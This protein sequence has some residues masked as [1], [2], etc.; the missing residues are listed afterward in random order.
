MTLFINNFVTLNARTI[1]NRLNLPG[2]D[3]LDIW[4]YSLA[5]LAVIPWKQVIVYSELDQPFA[6]RRAELDEFIS[7]LFPEA[8]IYHTR[9]TRQSQWLK[10]LE[11]VTEDN[12]WLCC[13]DDHPFLDY[14]L[15][16]LNRA[17]DLMKD[18]EYC[19]T[20]Y[21][22]WPEIIRV[23]RHPT[24]CRDLEDHGDFVSF[25][26]DSPDSI[27]IFTK[28]QLV[29]VFSTGNHEH[30]HLPR[31]DWIEYIQPE[32][33]KCFVPL[34]EWCRHFD[35]YSHIKYNQT[36]CPPL[37]IPEGFFTNDI[38]ILFGTDEKRPGWTTV[39][40]VSENKPFAMDSA[41][42]HETFILREIPLFWKDRVSEVSIVEHPPEKIIEARNNL[43][44]KKGLST[45][46]PVGN[47]EGSPPTNEEW[48]RRSFLC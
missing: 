35:G 17:L 2:F 37:S 28:K 20:Y 36:W 22:H 8:K 45:H 41:G 4:K 11:E 23:A 33:Y 27:Q 13:N 31:P 32:P 1:Y 38:K 30:K 24:F 25:T 44:L 19:T 10:A 26:W 48:I 18:H 39:N 3:R 34:R 47:W 29:R 42:P 5:S 46:W 6:H 21:S 40:P 12:I 15:E 43:L 9:N 7:S 14:N 16:S